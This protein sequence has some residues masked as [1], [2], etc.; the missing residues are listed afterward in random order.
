V[1]AAVGHPDWCARGHRCGLGEHRSEP[2]TL[3]APGAGRVVITRV[4]ATNGADHA[5]ITMRVVLP[6]G[7]AP[8][9]QR[10]SALLTHLRTLLGPGRVDNR[11]AKRAA[12]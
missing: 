3:A 9:R 8:A 1:N 2:L 10:L 4:H 12:S 6:T 11:P 7:E 5:E